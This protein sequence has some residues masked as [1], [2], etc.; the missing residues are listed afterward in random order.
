MVTRGLYIEAGRAEPII[1]PHQ[2]EGVEALWREAE[3]GEVSP[4]DG[5][6]QPFAQTH[7]F[8]QGAGAGFTEE[9]D[10]IQEIVQMAE[11]LLQLRFDGIIGGAFE[12]VECTL[13][14]AVVDFPGHIA[15]AAIA[16]L[17]E[18]P[19]ISKGIGDATQGGADHHGAVAVLLAF[20]RQNAS[21]GADAVRIGNGGTSEFQD[22][23]GRSRLVTTLRIVHREVAISV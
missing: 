22:L 10:A 8:V 6:G 14:V 15:I 21:A 13:D 5:H 4:E 9:V 18:T 2:F 16:R 1:G 11:P 19:C 3:V 12:Q 23:H 17:G 7:E 20:V